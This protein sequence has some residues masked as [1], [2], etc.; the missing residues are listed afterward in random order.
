M[1]TVHTDVRSWSL[2]L[3][4]NVNSKKKVFCFTTV[5]SALCAP[6]VKTKCVRC[7]FQKQRIAFLMHSVRTNHS[8]EAGIARYFFHRRNGARDYGS[9]DRDLFDRSLVPFPKRKA[10]GNPAAEAPARC[11]H[12]P[13]TVP[14]RNGCGG[15]SNRVFVPKRKGKRNKRGRK[16]CRLR[17]L[18]VAVA[19][20]VVV[21]VAVVFWFRST[22]SD[23]AP[24]IPRGRSRR[25]T[26]A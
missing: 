6:C 26:H 12:P 5:L 7:S 9:A 24:R 10:R 21:M 20:A 18:L 23:K 22:P 19:V 2:Q 17:F 16:G 3:R 14:C 15:I 4:S 8:Q 13:V 1:N 25:N 11:M